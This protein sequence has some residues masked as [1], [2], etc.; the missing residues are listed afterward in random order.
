VNHKCS[1][2][3]KEEIP[4]NWPSP[5]LCVE[6]SQ[7]QGA[8]PPLI[9]G[10]NACPFCG[11]DGL[12]KIKE[13]HKDEGWVQCS[14]CHARGPIGRPYQLATYYWNRRRPPTEKEQP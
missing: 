10:L 5:N 14:I 7:R 12:W 2:C 3:G 1:A 8:N 11:G 13:D 6:C 4:I 9:G